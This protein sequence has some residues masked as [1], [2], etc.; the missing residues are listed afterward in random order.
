MIDVTDDINA[1]VGANDR[2][3]FLRLENSGEKIVSSSLTFNNQIAVTTYSPSHD[4]ASCDASLGTGRIYALNVLNGAPVLNF[5]ENG[6]DDE[7]TEQD[8]L[9]VLDQSGIPPEVSI[10]FPQ[11]ETN[12]KP[13]F[14]VGKETIEEL[15]GG[16]PRKTTFWQEV[17]EGHDE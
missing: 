11:I 13:F 8:R 3:W 15:D 10:L 14:Q 2:G 9:R 4:F 17:T 5:D 7:L 12:E 1:E 16:E 6:S